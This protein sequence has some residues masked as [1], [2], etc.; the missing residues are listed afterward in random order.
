M[1]LRHNSPQ[2]AALTDYKPYILRISRKTID[3]LGVKLYDR[4]ALVI[5][6]LVSNS[7]DAD[8]RDVTVRAPAGQFLA[9]RKAGKVEDKGYEIRVEDDG[10]GMNP[11]QLNNYYLVVGSDRRLDARGEL[12]PGGRPVMG[13]KG[14]GKLAPFGICK[15]IEIV[16]AGEDASITPPDPSRPYHTSHVILNYD[17]ITEQDDQLYEPDRGE[18]DRTFTDKR[19]TTIILREFLTR[20]V[21]DVEALT[22]QIAQRFGKLLDASTFKVSLVDNAG[23]PALAHVVM[24]L[25]LPQMPSTRLN[26]AGPE[27]TLARDNE[28]G[29]SA[30][31]ELGAATPLKAG[32]WFEGKFY[33]VVGWVGYSKEPVKRDI[34]AGIRIY[35]RKK[36]AAQTLS[37]EMASGFHGEYQVK[38]YLIGELY[39][40]WLDEEED[41][42]H[43]D[44]QNIQWS[45]D[46]GVE[47]QKWGQDVIREIGRTARQPAAEN[48]LDLFKKTIDLTSELGRRFPDKEQG[49]IRKRAKN[50]AETLARKM[51][52]EEAADPQAA[53]EVITLASAFA[54]HLAL[55]D[56]LNSAAEAS[57]NLN[58]GMVA[59]ILSRAKLAENMTLGTIAEK[60]LRM[61]EQ[62]RRLVHAKPASDEDALQKILEEAPWLIRPEWTPISENKSLKRVRESLER[63]LSDRLGSDVVLSAVLHPTKRPDFVLLGIQGPLQ[64]VEIK[65]PAHEFDATDF[66]RLLRYV[67]AFDEFFADDSNKS[68][69]ADVKSYKITLVAD[70]IKLNQRDMLAFNQLRTQDK[71]EVIRWD[72]VLDHSRMVHQDFLDG[73]EEAGLRL[74]ISA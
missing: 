34:A 17:K 25:D 32:F 6:E 50:I 59:S 60:R 41:L 14:V 39:C 45:S 42:I 68:A 22:E 43:T 5:S 72:V 66:T 26:F 62:F 7:Y 54:P 64:I 67:E 24:P 27:P 28:I 9:T 21:P 55:S 35:C 57:E 47:F 18:K 23:A 3:K 38:S 8:A 69:L 10:L 52:P 31:H 53:K 13:R 37:F 61:I 65:K 70:G 71:L 12:S 40:D 46:V 74:E 4:V 19:G 30:A 56:E 63:F 1:G 58:V 16:S 2:G 20:R 73:L 29:Y 15:T 44:R 48:T 11:D 49:E 33:P 51:N 36:F